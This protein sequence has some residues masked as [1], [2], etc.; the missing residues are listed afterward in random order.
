MLHVEDLVEKD[1]RLIYPHLS[2]GWE[3][4]FLDEEKKTWH[5]QKNQT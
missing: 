1:S 5:C 2:S 4:E 3:I